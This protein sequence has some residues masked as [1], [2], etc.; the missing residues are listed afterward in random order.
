[1]PD[2]LKSRNKCWGWKPDLPDQRDFLYHSIMP[3]D[4][5]LPVKV[6][7]RSG[8]SPV[9]DQGSLGSCTAQ[10]LIGALEFLEIKDKVKYANLSRRF[11]YYNE[12]VIENSVSEDS[13]ATIRDGIKSL[14]HDGVCVE[15]RCPYRISSFASKPSKAS[16]ADALDHQIIEYRR[17]LTVKEMKNCLVAGFPFVFG[18]SVYESFEADEVAQT[19]IVP[20][21]KQREQLLGGHAVM[22]VGYNDSTERFVVRNSWG[23]KWGMKGYFTLPYGY[24]TDRNLSDDFWMI[25]RGEKV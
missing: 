18:F 10:A 9:E 19:G 25:R 15:R 24:F 8:C 4:L 16:Y 17:L 6:D 22:A 12:R 11:L 1:M 14:A 23:T 20:M 5:I 21:P 2:Q 3:P 13:G 7:L